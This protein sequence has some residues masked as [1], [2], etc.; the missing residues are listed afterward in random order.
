MFLYQ[1]LYDRLPLINHLRVI[2]CLYDAKNLTEH[3]KMEFR[4]RTA[5]LMGYSETQ[6]GYILYDLSNKSLF[7]SRDTSFQDSEFPFHKT[8]SEPSI[9]V[10]NLIE[11]HNDIR[12]TTSTSQYTNNELVNTS[13]EPADIRSSMV[14]VTSRVR[15]HWALIKKS[16]RDTH[17][18][19]WVKHFV[20]LSLHLDKSL[21]PLLI[22]VSYNNISFN[23]SA[24]I[25]AFS[26]LT[27]PKSYV[28]VVKDPK[29]V[30]AMQAKIQA[31]QDNKTWEVVQ[32][33]EKR[34]TIAAGGFTR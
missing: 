24:F 2:G 10:E 9:F 8:T 33:P 17:S 7:V 4:V 27:E 15:S 12:R 11:D 23:Y 18:P 19:I 30:Q 6:K 21:Y 5:V 25:L 20:S 26:S 13:H 28:E 16:T 32:L 3:N 14:P 1:K 34:S 31:L 22:Y 29:W